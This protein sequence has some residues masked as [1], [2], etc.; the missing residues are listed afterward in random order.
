MSD[1][2][3]NR[4]AADRS[5]ISLKESWEVAYWTKALG[6][7]KQTLEKAVKAVGHSADKIRQ[8]LESKGSH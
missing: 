3:Q 8:Y 6:C 4:G 5:R 7:D 1:N 2:L